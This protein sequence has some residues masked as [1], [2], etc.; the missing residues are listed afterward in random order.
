[1]GIL[2]L[3]APKGSQDGNSDK[4]IPREHVS[5]REKVRRSD[6]RAEVNRPLD[7]LF[8]LFDIEIVVFV[9]ETAFGID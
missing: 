8:T 5:A 7:V 6:R 4:K 9:A 1:M 3:L 2:A